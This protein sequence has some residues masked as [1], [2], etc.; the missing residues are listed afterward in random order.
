MTDKKFEEEIASSELEKLGISK[1]KP[2]FVYPDTGYSS[3][4]SD[5]DYFLDDDID[6][7][8]ADHQDDKQETLFPE[9]PKHLDRR[10]TK[11]EHVQP[12]LD[13]DQV[14]YS[15]DEYNHLADNIHR[16]M[17]DLLEEHQLIFATGNA[18]TR[19]KKIMKAYIKSQCL[20]KDDE[21]YKKIVVK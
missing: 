4:N 2:K 6:S 3:T 18:S 1:P 8:F 21:E 19:L 17:C 13:R 7:I 5:Q 11:V 20:Y 14:L 9:I 10:K 15:V 16:A 12:V